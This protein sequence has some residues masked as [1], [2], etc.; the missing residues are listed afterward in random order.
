MKVTLFLADAAQADAA[1]K[2]SALGLGW[3]RCSTP[4]PP[5]SLVI[6]LDIAW[7]E[8][9]RPHKLKIELLTTD[10]EPVMVPGPVGPQP[11]SFEAVAEAGR[12]AG[13]IRGSDLRMPMTLGITGG[14]E[15]AP[16]RY[17]WRVT[18]EG[19]EDATAVESFVVSGPGT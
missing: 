11:I 7:D 18:V 4:T 13:L 15:L 17:E 10:A 2:V 9:N 8:S 6:L 3:N 16:G 14:L 5:L 19:F 1:G 12:P